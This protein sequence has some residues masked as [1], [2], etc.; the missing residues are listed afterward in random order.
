[1][2]IPRLKASINGNEIPR[3]A[4]NE[5]YIGRDK[6]YL[7][8]RCKIRANGK[9]ESQKNS[10]ILVGTA[11]GSN[12]WIGSAGARKLKINRKRI[13]FVVRELYKS[14]FESHY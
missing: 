11:A 1:M 12:A 7:M 4:L 3:S 14:K 8:F 2:S 5:F 9:Q 10:G 13:Q 6:A